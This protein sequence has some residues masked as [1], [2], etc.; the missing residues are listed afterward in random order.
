MWLIDFFFWTVV[1]QMNSLMLLD[2]A[3]L[4][5]HYIRDSH[6]HS[7]ILTTELRHWRLISIVCSVVL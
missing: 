1:Q 7:H 2:T 6:R 4:L 3:E 5:L